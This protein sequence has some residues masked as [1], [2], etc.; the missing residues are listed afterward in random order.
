[1]ARLDGWHLAVTPISD[2]F[3]RR[4]AHRQLMLVEQL[5]DCTPVRFARARDLDRGHHIRFA[6]VYDEVRLVAEHRSLPGF[7]EQLRIRVHRIHGDLV[8]AA[9]VA[10]RPR[11]GE[12]L[13]LVV[14][15][16][17]LAHEIPSRGQLLEKRP[18]A[19]PA[20]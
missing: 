20:V 7:V 14:G 4:S 13:L 5:P 17:Q 11:L 6:A 18:R 15:G 10:A 16:P 3:P 9:S 1:V 19:Q 8:D 2:Q 12:D